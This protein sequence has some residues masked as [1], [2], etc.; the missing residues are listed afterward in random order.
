MNAPFLSS[1][2]FASWLPFAAAICVPLI[3]LAVMGVFSFRQSKDEAEL[4]AQRTVQ[5]LAEHALRTFRA[6]DLI[7]RAVDGHIAGWGWDAINASRPLHE[8]FTGLIRNADDINTIFVI[9]PTGREGNSS[10][11][12]P[13]A[14]T[15]MT[16]RPFYED[17]RHQGGLHVSEPDVGR[18]NKQRYF[19]FT[20]RRTTSDGTFDGVISVSVN[21]AYFEA[22][23]N[24]VAES[25]TDSVALVR[26]DGMLLVRVPIAQPAAERM[27]PRTAGSLM[28]AIADR[29]EA[30]T[31]S[32]RGS[33]DGIE[34]IYSYR[35]VGD[36]PLYASYGLSYDT[37]WAAWRHNML[38]YAL[39]CLTAVGL[40]IAAAVLVRRHDRR[41]SEAASRYLQETARR[42]AAEE[43]NRSKD[44]FLATLGHELRNPLSSISASAEILRRANIDDVNAA[45]AVNIIGRQVEHLRRLL[46]DLLDVARSIYGKMNLDPQI[47]SLLDVATSVAATYTG[48]IRR[49]VS[50]KIGGVRGWARVDPTRLRQMVEN[51]VDNAQKYG[52]SNIS[53]QVTES[54]DWVELT[55][56]DDGNGIPA[57]LMPTLFEPFVQGK[58]A[59]DRAAGGLGLGLALCK[60][61]AVAHGGTLHAVS[62][63]PGKGSK[64]TIRLPRSPSPDPAPAD[65][66]P[67]PR[68]PVSRVLVVEDQQDA[69]DSLRML[70]ELD[71]H[72]VETAASGREGVAKFD[73][74]LPDVVLVDI[75]LPEMTGH[76]VARAIRSRAS[77]TDVRLIALTGYGQPDDERRSRQ[78][79]FD[80]HLT[81][82]VTY[83][84]LRQLLVGEEP[85]RI[86][87]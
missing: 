4:R 10:L 49:E 18:I 26:S 30:G 19:S 85:S 50:I 47:V 81:K 33:V 72:Q 62:D 31:F 20:R 77:G 5:A 70:L 46:N 87:R 17:L 21:P 65:P 27:L 52:A 16:S 51:L 8:F 79:G 83:D 61:L 82:P 15:D 14:P 24:T 23:Y 28:A 42:M 6:H 40:L 35:R 68:L 69:R 3:L 76:E 44:E 48:A 84:K 41:E 58:Q 7:I 54:S 45:G 12:F 34:R 36:Y 13:L 78:A 11:V 38:A 64:F 56:A 37:V 57:E 60:R 66:A 29:P 67:P 43:T 73:A 2:R 75:G 55:V 86:E 22:F 9:G 74:F 53:V 59:L 71:N 32:Q 25:P 80:Y 63:G 39:V 1:K